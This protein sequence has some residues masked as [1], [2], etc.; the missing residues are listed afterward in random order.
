MLSALYNLGHPL[1]SHGSTITLLFDV[2]IIYKWAINHHTFFPVMQTTLLLLHIYP[3][4][5]NILFFYCRLLTWHDWEKSVDK[6]VRTI[7]VTLKY[8]VIPVMK[9]L[10]AVPNATLTAAVLHPVTAAIQTATL[11]KC[12][13]HSTSV[14]R[15]NGPF[16]DHPK[17]C[18][19]GFKIQTLAN[20]QSY[21]LYIYLPSSKYVLVV[22][23]YFHMYKKTLKFKNL[24]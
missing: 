7:Q 1:I 12:R 9:I 14:V 17:F 11:T 6:Q 3:S 13:H 21:F 19:K 15:T 10:A 16:Q 2:P 24:D 22:Y 23:P 4:W 8:Q 18:K 5:F 20:L